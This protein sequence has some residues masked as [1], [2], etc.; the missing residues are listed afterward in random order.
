MNLYSERFDAQV[1]GQ[2][3]A[4]FTLKNS[5]GMEASITNYGGKVVSLIVPDKFGNWNDVVLGFSSIEAYLSAN[6][7]Y[8]GALIGRYGN[9]IAQGKFVLNN[10]E[11]QLETNNGAHHLH[12]GKKGFNAVVW[13]AVQI[14]DTTLE[15]SYLS[16]DGEEAY[17]GNLTVKVIYQLTEDNALR[18]DYEAETDAPTFV[19]LTHHSF[20]N[21]AGEA[22]GNIHHHI[23]TIHA[24]SY[25]PV[26]VGLIPT[27]EILPVKGTSF[28]FTNPKA[29][30]KDIESD[31]FQLQLGNGYD[32][33]FVLNGIIKNEEG[34]QLAA[35]VVEPDSGRKMEV[36]TTEPGI[37]LY[38]GNFLQ[39]K[40]IGKSGKAYDFRTAFCLETQHFPDSPNQASFPPTLLLPGQIFKSTTLYQ[41][42]ISE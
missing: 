39:G 11:Y 31:D 22:S 27:G 16:P 34:L 24:N 21:L 42:S 32:H 2:K 41:F 8:F 35:S 36:W 26:D 28:D 37:Q 6:E 25:T 40:D 15:L 12:G 23:L 29:I 20:F 9:R 33:N 7:A 13:N 5:N 19:N 1:D 18:I 4:L 14:N 30:G 17:P 38:S 3:T 10:Q